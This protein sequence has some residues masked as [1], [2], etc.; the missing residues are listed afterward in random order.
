VSPPADDGATWLA[1][2]LATRD[3]ERLVPNMGAAGERVNDAHRHIRS[4]RKL[5][6]EDTTLAVAACHDAIRKAITGH[7][8]A[9]GYRPKGGDGAHRIVLDYAR[10]QRIGVVNGQ[11]LDDADAIRRDRGIAEYGDF[12]SL[13]I[14]AAHVVWAADVAE[15]FVTAVATDLAS[16]QKRSRGTAF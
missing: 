13:K 4:A 14:D 10:H 3:V 12:A 8:A 15:R 7:M 6:S 16:Q 1:E 2:A 11:D 5:A 9:A